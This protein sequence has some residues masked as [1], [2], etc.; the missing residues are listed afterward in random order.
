LFEQRLRLGNLRHF[1]CRP[2]AFE[3][4]D[5]DVL[6]KRFSDLSSMWLGESEKAIAAAFEEAADLRA[7]VIFDEA[8]SLLRDRLA[9]HQS[10]RSRRS[11]K[12]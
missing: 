10:W 1:G 6:E 5:L 3:R 11:M 9:A 7:F 2:E 8:D 4:L 12:C